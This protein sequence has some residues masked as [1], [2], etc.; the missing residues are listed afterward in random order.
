M[1]SKPTFIYYKD[2]E[3]PYVL[4]FKDFVEVDSG[5]IGSPTFPNL[6]HIAA[7]AMQM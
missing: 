4:I 5:Y 1:S 7:I 6:R 2:F 3:V